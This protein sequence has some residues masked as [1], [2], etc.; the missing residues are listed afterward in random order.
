MIP[1]QGRAAASSGDRFDGRR[2]NAAFRGAGVFGEGPEAVP[3]QV[4]EHL[5]TDGEPRHAWPDRL[6]ATGKVRPERPLPRTAQTGH[7]AG[8]RR[9]AAQHVE[10]GS[11][12]RRRD[13][14][15]EHLAV[16]DDW[17]V[18][19]SE[20]DLLGPAVSVAN[21]RLHATILP[22]RDRRRGMRQPTGAAALP[23][24]RG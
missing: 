2:A 11:V 17:S 7:D 1:D 18:D 20:P 15:D 13:Y 10:I 3:R 4:A 22:R 12:D 5:V 19:V 14:P 16:A 21:D 8:E 23:V 6:D 9:A 24:A